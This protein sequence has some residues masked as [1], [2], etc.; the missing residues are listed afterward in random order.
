[1]SPSVVL[2]LTLFCFCSSFSENKRRRKRVLTCACVFRYAREHGV[3]SDR[4]GQRHRQ[5][6]RSTVRGAGQPR[7]R[8][9]SELRDGRVRASQR[10][11]V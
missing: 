8:R 6:D 1:M 10:T 9:V 11:L 7:L 5:E 2:L 4:R 3:V